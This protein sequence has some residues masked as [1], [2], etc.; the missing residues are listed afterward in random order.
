M[1]DCAASL[2]TGQARAGSRFPDT[3]WGLVLATRDPERERQ[4][5]AALCESYRAPVLAT[6][7]RRGHATPDAED[8]VQ[9]F[10]LHLLERSTVARADPARGRFRSFML[11]ALR[12]YLANTLEHQ[13]A[14]R[15]HAPQ[16]ALGLER[17]DAELAARHASAEDTTF[18]LQFDREWASALVSHALEN[19]RA[20]YARLGQAQVFDVLHATLDPH[21]PAPTYASLA[22]RLARN[23][24]AVKV[25]VHRLRHRFREMLRAEV[26]RTVAGA[27]E[28]DDE[29]RHLRHVL[30]VEPAADFA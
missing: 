28:V 20:E 6:L 9:G 27:R 22:G 3:S 8:L 14:A 4:A 13:Q 5:F 18:E 24:G 16:A 11:G 10:F 2:N 29:M 7:R 12:W 23:E 15:R 25:A 21:G 19:L 17:A 26:A 30:T 1:T